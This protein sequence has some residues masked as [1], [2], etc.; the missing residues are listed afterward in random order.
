MFRRLIERLSKLPTPPSSPTVKRTIAFVTNVAQPIQVQPE[1]KFDSELA[2]TR[3]R[4][5]IS[6]Q[7]QCGQ[8]PIKPLAPASSVLL[9]GLLQAARAHHAIQSLTNRLRKARPQTLYLLQETFFSYCPF[10]VDP[11]VLCSV[12]STKRMLLARGSQPF[13]VPLTAHAVPLR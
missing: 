8:R 11:P 1:S 9:H 4:V 10:W 12:I 7:P 2:S 6:E 13:F 3:L 5:H